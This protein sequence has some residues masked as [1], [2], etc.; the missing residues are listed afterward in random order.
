MRLAK[1]AFA[2]RALILSHAWLLSKSPM[3]ILS[4]V[5]FFPRQNRELLLGAVSLGFCDNSIFTKKNHFPIVC[6]VENMKP[7]IETFWLK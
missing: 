3:Q 2:R 6:T 7:T 5:P 1:L 4:K